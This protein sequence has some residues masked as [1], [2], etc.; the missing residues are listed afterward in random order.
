MH[1][2][3][4]Y[5]YK[6]FARKET[7]PARIGAIARLYGVN[8]A[9]VNQC[10]VFEIGCGD[11]SNIIS[12]AARYPNSRFVG[13]DLSQELI[14][15]GRREAETL[16]LSNIELISGDIS[17]YRPTVASFDYVIC[18]GVYSWVSPSVRQAI[19]DR[20]VTALSSQ[21]VLFVSYNTLP[22]WRQR[23]ALRDIMGVGAS[24]VEQDGDVA[25][26]ENAMAFLSLITEHS[27]AITP[28]VR[29]A[30][31]RLK[32]SDPSYIIQEFLGEYN[33]PFMFTD[34]MRDAASTGFQF[35]SEARV[36]M[37]SSED[38]SPEVNEVLDSLSDNI[39]AREQVIDV[40]RNRMFRE[41]LLCHGS[42]ALDRGLSSSVFK[43]LYFV[44]TYL[45]KSS[46]IAEGE[47]AFVERFSGRDISVPA[48]ECATVLK[49]IANLGPRG[50]RFEEIAQ[51]TSKLHGLEE[52]EL[53]KVVYTLWKTGFIDGLTAPVCGV[54]DLAAVNPVARRQA[55]EGSLV[56]S[57]LHESFNLS[58]EERAVLAQVIA[59]MSFTALE[60]IM[61]ASF[62][63]AR[64]AELISG[65]KEKGFFI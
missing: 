60:T 43:Q 24:F 35:L 37:M 27:T 32:N 36:V 29:E 54:N 47:L 44:A 4:P 65:L 16:E 2:S 18:H 46:K 7:H 49:V 19:L 26:L 17:E 5:L 50:A 55:V 53:F 28:Y 1:Q 21:G 13:I 57:E 42:V 31:E 15:K 22:G 40:A 61:L 3:T 8:A 56:T 12:L 59:P 9:P 63:K 25:R 45:P 34:F 64:V 62:P 33:T 30:A 39:V 10:A 41:T 20:A 14:E 23:G 48:G 51:V 11:G 6:T 58:A 38:L 52:E